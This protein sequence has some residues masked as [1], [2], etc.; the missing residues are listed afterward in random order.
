[1]D[2]ER[3]HIAPA[4]LMRCGS[5]VGLLVAEVDRR[6]VC[7]RAKKGKGR[8]FRKEADQSGHSPRSWP[9]TAMGAVLPSEADR[10]PA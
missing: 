3:R 1:M 4:L 5:S 8:S 6:A 7:C 2:F 10:Q 9:M